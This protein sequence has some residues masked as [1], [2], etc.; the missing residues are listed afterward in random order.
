MLLAPRGQG[1]GSEYT[2]LHWRKCLGKGLCPSPENFSYF[3]VV[4]NAIFDTFW[5][6]Y[7]LNPT[8]MRGVLTP[9]PSSVRHCKWE[10]WHC[11]FLTSL[12]WSRVRRSRRFYKISRKKLK[13]A[14]YLGDA[15]SKP[16]RQWH[17]H[18]DDDWRHYRQ[19]S[20]R[21]RKRELHQDDWQSGVLDPSLDRYG[22]YPWRRLSQNESHKTAKQEADIRKQAT[23]E[24][25]QRMDQLKDVKIR[26]NAEREH[27]QNEDD[28][29]RPK[30][31]DNNL[32][33]TLAVTLNEQTD[34]HWN[35]IARQNDHDVHERNCYV[36]IITDKKPS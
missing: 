11:G 10:N 28:E 7:F 17:E 14:P 2:P 33:H 1:V 25:Q 9:N 36:H 6:V 26:P 27:E 18:R 4:E 24:Q 22:E 8:P 13:P 30:Q 16:Q 12:S 34:N 32:W 31:A 5:H 3:F 20:L 21:L 29:Q 35:Q 15:K 23:S 19:I